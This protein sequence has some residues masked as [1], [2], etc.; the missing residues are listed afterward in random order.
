MNSLKIPENGVMLKGSAGRD[1]ASLPPQAFAISLNDSVIEG[2]I[3]CVQNGGDIQLALGAR[4]VSG[5]NRIATYHSP[6]C[7]LLLLPEELW[8]TYYAGSRG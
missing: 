5:I 1:V 4:P 7:A 6:P 3:K 2:M 8:R